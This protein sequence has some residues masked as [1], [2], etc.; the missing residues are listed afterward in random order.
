MQA[1]AG[2]EGFLCG[3]LDEAEQLAAD[4]F[5]HLMYASP[6]AAGPSIQR[7]IALAKKVPDF[8]VR[9]DSLDA[10]EARLSQVTALLLPPTETPAPE[11]TIAPSGLFSLFH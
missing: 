11:P 5:Q 2:C 9:L 3:T 8:I 6:A 1:D 7:V 4:G 10:A